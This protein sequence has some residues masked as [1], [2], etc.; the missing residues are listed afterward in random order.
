[1][2]FLDTLDF[3]NLNSFPFHYHVVVV[4][5]LWHETST[6]VIIWCEY[7]YYVL[8]NWTFNLQ[9]IW[10]WLWWWYSSWYKISQKKFQIKSMCILIVNNFHVRLCQ[11]LAL[12]SS[13]VSH[14]PSDLQ[15]ESTEQPPWDQYL[16]DTIATCHSVL[17]NTKKSTSG[18]YQ[19]LNST[20]QQG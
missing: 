7:M 1:V 12:H 11:F 10:W 2:P 9:Q 6:S 18:L 15:S 14:V 19:T 3:N 16:S 5:E 8:I 13:R 4:H 20:L 17:Q